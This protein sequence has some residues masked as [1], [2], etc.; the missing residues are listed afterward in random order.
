[1]D[2]LPVQLS[3]ILARHKAENSFRTGGT[4]GGLVDFSS[5]DY[6]GLA[7]SPE[8]FD[9]TRDFLQQKKLVVNGAT[10]SRLITG[11]H[12]LYIE[13][14]ELIADFHQSECSL[15]F[16]SGYDANVG[17][18]SSVPQKGDVVLYDEYIHASIRDGIRL[19][20][21]QSYK[22]AHNDKESLYK[23]VERYRSKAVEIYI[24][25]EAV[26][27]MDGDT[28]NLEA[29][30]E[31]SERYKCRLVVDE[32]HSTGIFGERG[33][34]LLQVF[35][36]HKRVFARLISFGKALG[37]HGAAVLGSE[38]LVA[39]LANFARSFVYTTALPPHSLATI[40]SSYKLVKENPLLVNKLQTAISHFKTETERCHLPFIL[41][42]SAI[43]SIVIP[44]NDR[45]RKIAGM[46]QR[47]GYS[48]KAILSPNVPNGQE[49]LRFCVHSF[50]TRTEM[51]IMMDMLTQAIRFS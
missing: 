51:S 33:Q 31:I 9:A 1:M 23:L 10:G 8:L 24:V 15:I 38:E 19:S 29:F 20:G 34:G 25:T 43:H 27:S 16:N 7:S 30:A 40:I 32:A 36:L 47:A 41:S 5:N 17:F 6:L 46:L 22:F 14:E 39:Y 26:F 50:N 42:F 2:K 45:A 3:E 44:G 18:F 49:R 12:P 21:A 28:P 13:A 48:V 37:C 11:N 4:T 35:G